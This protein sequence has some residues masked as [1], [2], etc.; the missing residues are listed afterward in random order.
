MITVTISLIGADEQPSVTS[1]HRAESPWKAVER[2]VQKAFGKRAELNIDHGISMPDRGIWYG[3]PIKP[4]GSTIT[5]QVR[6]VTDER[7][8]TSGA[9]SKKTA[10]GDY[11]VWK[12]ANNDYRVA[13]DGEVIRYYRQLGPADAEAT[14]L[15]L[16]E[17]GT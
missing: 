14:R 6:V 7:V 16:R 15:H 4:S 13:H 10:A 8:P 1:R 2:A 3:Q 11:A 12:A 9:W 5:G 17:S